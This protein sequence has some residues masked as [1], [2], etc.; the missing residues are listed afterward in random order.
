MIGERQL[1]QT[2]PPSTR[3][4]VELHCLCCFSRPAPD[5]NAG[6]PCVLRAAPAPVWVSYFLLQAA[7]E[8]GANYF[9]RVNDDSEILT[10][11]ARHFV[12]AL[13]VR[14]MHRGCGSRRHAL[15]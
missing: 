15:A 5:L 9:Y 6:R 13:E 7:Y 12:D 14:R 3:S 1:S 8:R 2:F 4:L 10:P 11:W